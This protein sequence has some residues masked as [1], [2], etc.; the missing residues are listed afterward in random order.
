MM[1]KYVYTLLGFLFFGIGA[2]G[3]L[4]PVLP[5]TPF[6]LLAAFFFAKG[7]KR[8]H[9]WFTST[10]MYQTHLDSFVKERAMTLES[11]I[12][13]LMLASGMLLIAFIATPVLLARIVIVIVMV[14]KYVYFFTK[15]KTISS[16]QP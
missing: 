7:S 13:I 6:L 15:V 8:F 9:I 3:A 1:I 14:C 12:R 11:K 5:T 4:L 2:L 16:N 10:S